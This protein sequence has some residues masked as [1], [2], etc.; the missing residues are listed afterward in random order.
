M[1][2]LVVLILHLQAG[3]PTIYQSR[4]DHMYVFNDEGVFKFLCGYLGEPDWFEPKRC[5]PS[6]TTWALIDS[7]Q[8][9]INVPMTYQ[10]N[11]FIVQ[12]PSPR[13]DR[14]AWQRK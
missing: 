5:T 10:N 3:L 13:P 1:W 8:N 6:P 14:F 12:T 2:L 11:F 7:N 9:L 4:T